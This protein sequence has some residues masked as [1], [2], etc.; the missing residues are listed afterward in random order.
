MSPHE[1]GGMWVPNQNYLNLKLQSPIKD[2]EANE[3][4]VI[5][6]EEDM[7]FAGQMQEKSEKRRFLSYCSRFFRDELTRTTVSCPMDFTS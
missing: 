4:Y 1:Y 7:R 6:G 3:R 2:G 5:V